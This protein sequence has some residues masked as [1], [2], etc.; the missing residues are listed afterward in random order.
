MTKNNIIKTIKKIDGV[1]LKDTENKVFATAHGYDIEWE[2]SNL[3]CVTLCNSSKRHHYDAGSD[4]NP[5]GYIF[6]YKIKDIINYITN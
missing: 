5:F 6:V 1:I 2:A 3:R 4:Y